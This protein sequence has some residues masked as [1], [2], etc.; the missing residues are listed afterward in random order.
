M[1]I[2]EDMDGGLLEGLAGNLVHDGVCMLEYGDDVFL[3]FKIV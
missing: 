3:C 1:L 2:R